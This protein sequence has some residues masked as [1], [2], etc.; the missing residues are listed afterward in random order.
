MISK[1]SVGVLLSAFAFAI[2]APCGAAPITPAQ[3]PTAVVV[4]YVLQN[5]DQHVTVKD[6][7]GKTL[8]TAQAGTPTLQLVISITSAPPASPTAASPSL[9]APDSAVVKPKSRQVSL[10][11]RDQNGLRLWS[12]LLPMAPQMHTFTFSA[13][14]SSAAKG[15]RLELTFS[16]K[17]SETATASDESE[18]PPIIMTI[19]SHGQFVGM[20]G[21]DKEMKIA[22][23][24]SGVTF[25][26][27][28]GSG[29][30]ASVN[31]NKDA[32]AGMMVINGTQ[33]PIERVKR[34]GKSY[35]SFPWNG[36]KVLV[37]DGCN[38]SVTSDGDLTVDPPS[39]SK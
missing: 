29:E 5:H 28:D 34:N 21:A 12:Q 24:R 1:I 27:P 2:A 17:K 7:D 20:K 37:G 4:A 35:L 25:T 6:G 8:R 38:F 9:A 16:T 19:D 22:A 32:S 18:P 39:G 10:L 33:I 3:A 26:G 36:H 15:T 23:N 14:S 13:T 30:S 31:L 11:L